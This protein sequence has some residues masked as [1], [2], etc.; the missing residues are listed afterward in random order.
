L[1]ATPLPLSRTAIPATP[2]F[3]QIM[4]GKPTSPDSCGTNAQG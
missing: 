3:L 4:E 1:E 2:T